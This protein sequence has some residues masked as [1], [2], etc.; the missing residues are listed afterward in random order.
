MAPN[1]KPTIVLVAGAF[2]TP[3]SYQQLT[4]ALESYGYE[5]HVPRLPTCNE[6]RPPNADLAS[7]TQ[8]VRSY[9]ES[10]VRAGRTV[11]AIGHSYGGQV[12]S[13]A[14]CGLGTETRS[15]KGLAGGV[16][17]LIY[18][19][20]Y[21][22]AKGKSTFDKFL[23]FGDAANAPLVFDVAEDGTMLVKNPNVLF[24]LES[25]GQRISEDEVAAYRE[26]LC[27]WNGKG[28]LQPLENEAWREIESCYIYTQ[29]DVSIPIPEQESMVKTLEK[30]GREVKTASVESGHCP[31]FSTTQVVA[32]TVN[33][34]IQA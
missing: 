4:D 13:N 10:L 5:V 24:G 29:L 18:M 19:V 14:L 23:E 33:E 34:M 12:V 25:P 20:G 30:A 31:H 28:M 16:S 6:A 17:K 3:R 1:V 9:V 21:A 27:H 7:D 11:V 22:L 32:D 2:H 26:T 15:R 8:L